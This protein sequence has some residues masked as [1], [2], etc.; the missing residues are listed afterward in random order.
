M[1]K[2]IIRQVAGRYREGMG[3]V[4]RAML[5][6]IGVDYDQPITFHLDG[7][8][9]VIVTDAEWALMR[10]TW[11]DAMVAYTGHSNSGDI[12]IS[13]PE[14]DAYFESHS[15]TLTEAERAAH[16]PKPGNSASKEE[17]AR[18]KAALEARKRR[19][20]EIHDVD[21]DETVE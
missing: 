16:A 19:L 1:P 18:R 5:S 10:G 2:K 13:T 21:L 6:N 9:T 15:P 14:T 20:L 17:S 12:R 4:V 8:V 7:T 3:A 11:G